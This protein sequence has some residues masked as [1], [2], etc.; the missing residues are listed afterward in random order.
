MK[1]LF[2]N[3]VRSNTYITLNEVEKLIKNEY[4]ISNILNRF[5][6]EI[7]PNLGTKVDGRYLCDTSNISDPIQ[8]AIKK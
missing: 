6:T 7:V 2:S 3:K 8:K 5:F 4:Q 1:P